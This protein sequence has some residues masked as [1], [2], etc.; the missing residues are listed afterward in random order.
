MIRAILLAAVLPV[1]VSAQGI[2]PYQDAERVANGKIVYENNCAACHGA[3]L[4]GEPD[5]KSRD[6]NGLLRAPPHDETGHT[7][8]HPDMQLFAIVALGSEAVVGNGYKSRMMGFREILTEQ[9]VLDVMAYIKSTWPEDIQAQH[10][11]INARSQ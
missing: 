5:W 7:W 1:S 9:E 2:F 6:E 10:N 11:M 3:N 4:E 8:H